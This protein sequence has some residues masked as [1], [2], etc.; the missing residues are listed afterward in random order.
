MV[1]IIGHDTPQAVVMSG[2]QVLGLEDDVK[3]MFC[4]RGPIG[5]STQASLLVRSRNVRGQRDTPSA[6][7]F[8]NPRYVF[9]V[10]AP[11]PLYFKTTEH[12]H[13]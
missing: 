9:S 13:E 2:L 12:S 7:V 6:R 11:T 3:Y 8:L 10:E 4:P 5:C 1:S